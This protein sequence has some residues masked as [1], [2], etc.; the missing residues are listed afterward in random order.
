MADYVKTNW[1][2]GD[3]ITEAKLDN[4]ETQY[5]TAKAEYQSRAW[6][7]PRM[8][9]DYIIYKVD[10]TYYAQN[11]ATGVVDSTNSDASTVIQYACDHMPTIDY[12]AGAKPG[13]V[14]E[15]RF[16][17]YVI[18]TKIQVPAGVMLYGNGSRMD[19]TGLNDVCFYFNAGGTQTWLWGAI[20]GINGFFF[21]G[22]DPHTTNPNCKCAYFNN[23]T[24][25]VIVEDCVSLH[26]NYGI[27]IDNSTWFAKIFNFHMQFFDGVGIELKATV[28]TDSANG[29]EILNCDIEDGGSAAIGIH[30]YATT[31]KPLEEVKIM[32]CWF[33]QVKNPIKISGYHAIIDG[34]RL[35]GDPDYSGGYLLDIYSTGGH[36]GEENVITNNF[37]SMAGQEAAGIYIECTNKSHQIL[38]NVFH[39][40]ASGPSIKSTIDNYLIITGNTF[41]N[42]TGVSAYCSYLVLADN[43]FNGCTTGIEV[44]SGANFQTITGNTFYL[45]TNGIKDAGNATISGN[46]FTTITSGV[47]VSASNS[48]YTANKHL[49]CS[50]S[51][52]IT[53]S[54]VTANVYSSHTGTFTLTS[55]IVDENVGLDAYNIFSGSKYIV[56]KSASTYYAKNTRTGIVDSSGA[57]LSTVLQYCSDQLTSGGTIEFQHTSNTYE[58]TLTAPVTFG[59]GVCLLGNGARID[60]TAV[61]GCAFYFNYNGIAGASSELTTVIRDFC[62][63]DSTN[64]VDNLAIHFRSIRRGGVISNIVS[65]GVYNVVLV[66]GESYDTLIE[67]VTGMNCGG[68]FIDIEP[69]DIYY[70]TGPHIHACEFSVQTG[71]T[72]IGVKVASGCQNISITDS[73]FESIKYPIYDLGTFTKIQGNL[74]TSASGGAAIYEGGSYCNIIGNNIG[75]A[76]GILLIGGATLHTAIIGNVFRYCAPCIKGDTST[77]NKYCTIDGNILWIGDEIG[78]SGRISE[79]IISNNIFKP[80]TTPPLGT[81]IYF[82]TYG[83]NCSIEGNLFSGLVRGINISASVALK[84]CNNYDYN[85]TNGPILPSGAIQ[86]GNTGT[87]YL[88]QEA[89]GGYSYIIYKSGSTYYA[90]NGSTG[91]VDYSGTTCSTVIQS[92]VTAMGTGVIQF[93]PGTYVLTAEVTGTYG[94]F[95][96]GDGA[97]LD[98][99][100]MNTDVFDFGSDGTVPSGNDAAPLT[101]MR[102]FNVQGTASNTSCKLITIRN[103]R[104]NTFVEDIVTSDVANVVELRGACYG[105]VI[106]DVISSASY[107]NWI[108]LVGWLSGTVYAPNDTIIDHCEMSG[109]NTT[110]VAIDLDSGSNSPE[111]VR[112]TNCWIETVNIGIKSAGYHCFILGN[113]ISASAGTTPSN[114]YLNTGATKNQIVGNH[115]FAVDTGYGIYNVPSYATIN[116]ADNHFDTCAGQ[117]VCN[118]A[119]DGIYISATGNTANF[120]SGTAE[121]FLVG[122]FQYSSVTGNRLMGGTHTT[123]NLASSS[124]Y[125]T[126][127]G[128]SFQSGGSGVT[129]NGSSNSIIGNTFTSMTNGVTLT[130]LSSSTIEGNS[131]TTVTNPLIG[132]IG[133]NIIKANIGYITEKAGTDTFTASATLVITHGLAATPTKVL[134][135]GSDTN[136][137]ALWITSIGSTTFTINRDNST[138]TPAVYWYAEV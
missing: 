20:T 11:G 32:G 79:S 137:K 124:S 54:V 107:T 10:S 7:V 76:C 63:Y 15:F 62:F 21:K 42:G 16:A 27:T 100:G 127:T 31:T 24:Y 49:N 135:T 61:N 97:I 118:A 48:T 87:G 96:Q 82:D 101:G 44:L 4:C 138:G 55:S 1:A 35:A 43:N 84:V 104:F 45:C 51:S 39:G 113:F 116:I 92:A 68:I 6:G 23:I 56:Y 59:P 46:N 12:G 132:S 115:I 22:L 108:K 72:A 34:N 106:R 40:V 105:A 90:K 41:V 67:A 99:T 26:M 53:S 102:G 119:G 125:N 71:T 18:L 120:S 2:T 109:G 130:N 75:T 65:N 74:L 134:V 57:T 60:I 114:I 30:A 94:V 50:S 13:G 78:I 86:S 5:D 58:Y 126:I 70:P 95:L 117:A 52:S 19:C 93:R 38:N 47:L 112:I 103:A 131:F 85:C 29:T 81:G 37:F 64:D 98:V 88:N 123:I 91:V 129:I 69:Y 89:H 14:I 25:S 73:W 66:D 111:G 80:N 136:S 3:L 110:A 122:K 28:A 133:T 33:E 17:D 121:G 83:A 128:N 36:N 9:A 8:G 77:D